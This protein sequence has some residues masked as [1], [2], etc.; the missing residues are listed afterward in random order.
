MESEID[1]FLLPG[2]D[3]VQDNRYLSITQ[4][5]KPTIQTLSINLKQITSRSAII[6]QNIRKDKQV[7]IIK[8]ESNV[9]IPINNKRTFYMWDIYKTPHKI[10]KLLINIHNEMILRQKNKIYD[11]NSNDLKILISYIKFKTNDFLQNINDIFGFINSLIEKDRSLLN[12]ESFL[13]FLEISCHSFHLYNEGIKPLEGY[14]LKKAENS[15]CRCLIKWTCCCFRCCCCQCCSDYNKRWFILKNDMIC[16]LN[17][18]NDDIGK[19]IFWFDQE[20]E[21]SEYDPKHLIISI[22]NQSR[23][24][25]LKFS[26][27]FEYWRWYDEI[28]TRIESFKQNENKNIYSSF[29][30]KKEN[31]KVNFFVDAHD[32]FQEL[33]Q[34]LKSARE[35]IYIT[36]W[37]MSPELTLIRPSQ[38]KSMLMDIFE[39]RAKAGVKIYI[40]VF[41]EMSWALTLDSLHTKTVLNNLHKNIKVTRHP[42]GK[43]ELLWS[44]H[45]KIVIIDQTIAYVGGLDLCWGRYD[46]SNHIL[47]ENLMDNNNTHFPGIDYSNTRIQDFIKVVQYDK[48][49][50]NRKTTP[51]MPWHDVHSVLRGE[52]VFDLT[53]HFV[54][55]W[56]FSRSINQKNKITDV[57]TSTKNEEIMNSFGGVGTLYPEKNKE[58]TSFIIKVNDDSIRKVNTLSC[59]NNEIVIPNEENEDDVNHSSTILTQE[60]FI[61]KSEINEQEGNGKI[62]KLINIIGQKIKEKTHKVKKFIRRKTIMHKNPNNFLDMNM[63]SSYYDMYTT[64][65]FS[66]KSSS[67][68]VQLLRSATKWSCGLKNTENSILNGYYHLIENS[69]HYIYIENQFF[70]S[71]SYSDEELS[72]NPSLQKLEPIYNRIAEK[73]Y[74]RIVKAYDNQEKFRVF[75]FIPLLPSFEGDIQNSPTLQVILKYTYCGI[76]RNNSFSLIEKLERKMGNLW[77]EYLFFFSL[78]TH[79]TIN[80]VPV[81]EMIYIHSKLMIVDDDYVLLGSANINDRS[82]K[83]TRDSEVAIIVT[84]EEKALGTVDNQKIEISQVAKDLRIRLMQEHLGLLGDRNNDFLSNENL[85]DPLS[86]ILFTGMK[87]IAANNTVIYRKVFGCY[88]DDLYTRFKDIKVVNGFDPS[89]NPEIIEKLKEKYHQLKDG[90]IGNI[91]EF[92]LHFL[93]DEILERPLFCKEKLVPI[94]NFT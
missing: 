58:D 5:S 68:T 55:R 3:L 75:V 9:L 80:D 86:D 63:G 21:I 36:D 52:I 54:E 7:I 26:N 90:I 93:E 17:N 14:A 73:L 20:N 41:N 19:D 43:F 1:T 46:T 6:N 13:E 85:D 18:L 56:N 2:K 42:K 45:E 77:K 60:K 4:L 44:H 39:E 61:N 30:D 70:V 72:L 12:L 81:T 94:K 11:Y 88:P 24:L 48:D 76:C 74:Q 35:T 78:R 33:S 50:I 62:K 53:R 87:T 49:L 65:N 84:D 27:S 59:I 31:N 82:L 37:W 66:L 40:L 8:V 57:R 89:E 64:K 22:S 25:V 29:V 79:A 28:K 51:R 32:Y 91:V 83:G 71:R 67:K 10:K 69:K 92:P 47:T 15:C 23:H 38:E 16:Y 34:R